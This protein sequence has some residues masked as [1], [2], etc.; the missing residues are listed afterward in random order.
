MHHTARDAQFTLWR[1]WEI[2]YDA[3][4]MRIRKC[5]GCVIW[6]S[7]CIFDHICIFT[8]Y[9]SLCACP[10][11]LGCIKGVSR[12]H[13]WPSFWISESQ[14]RAS[15]RTASIHK[16]G[17]DYNMIYGNIYI[18]YYNTYIYILYVVYIM[19]WFKIYRQPSFLPPNIASSC[20][21]SPQTNSGTIGQSDNRSTSIYANNHWT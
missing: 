15:S 19:N 11:I 3:S 6:G 1:S 21:F 4:W 7:S 9:S 14:K 10:F 13:C 17:I 16:I 5:I 8:A 18:L 12:R 20:R 2:R